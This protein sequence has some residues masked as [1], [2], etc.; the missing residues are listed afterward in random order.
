MDDKNFAVSYV[1]Q[2]TVIHQTGKSQPVPRNP[3][4][5][6]AG[7]LLVWCVAATLYALTL[8]GLPYLGAQFDR[9]PG[10]SGLVITQLDPDGP[11][12]K[13]GLKQDQRVLTL[14]NTAGGDAYSFTDIDRAKGRHHLPTY[15]LAAQS[16]QANKNIWALLSAEKVVFVDTDGR[17]F[18]LAPGRRATLPAQSYIGLAVS[19]AVFL[20][21]LGIFSFAPLN[22][23]NGLLVATGL[24]LTVVC[25]VNTAWPLHELA[26]PPVQKQ[27]W[28]S[29]ASTGLI[30]FCYGLLGLIWSVPKPIAGFPFVVASLLAGGIIAVSNSFELIEFPIHTYQFPLVITLPLAVII[31]VVQFFRTRGKPLERAAL[32]WFVLSIYS[33]IA[34]VIGLFSAPVLLGREPHLDVSYASYL[35]ALI[36]I[37]FA[38]GT[39]RVRLFDVNRLWLRALLWISGGVLVILL[40]ILLIS[41]FDLTQASSL[42][43]ALLIVGWIYFPIRQMIFSRFAAHREISLARVV[44]HLIEVFSKVENIEEID[45]RLVAFLK[46]VFDASELG[47]ARAEAL[48]GADVRQNGLVLQVPNLVNDRSFELLGK[49]RGR[50]LFSAGDAR[51]ANAILGLVRSIAATKAEQQQAM[52]LQKDA[53]VRDLHDEVGGRLLDIV[54]GTDEQSANQAREALSALKDVLLVIEDTETIE[55]SVALDAIISETE[56]RLK[57]MEFDLRIHRSSKLERILSTREYANLK[58]LFKE[59]V[60]NIIKF[61]DRAHPVEMTVDTD[62]SGALSI[63]QCNRFTPQERDAARHTE[64][65]GR[66]L[67]NMKNR[68][69]ELGGKL[70]INGNEEEDGRALFRLE[71]KIPT[72]G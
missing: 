55:L 48:E 18:E 49:K 23:T 26:L 61:A 2:S 66:G 7:G 37:G 20:I 71:F 46:E 35:L 31:S 59:L 65:T 54:Y 45:G 11:M 17:K 60:N 44:P 34:L 39:L 40:D 58:R 69:E 41:Q 56:Q 12:A 32:L 64:V 68:A 28:L 72:G 4:L 42:T 21:T 29:L 19:F 52:Q 51:T 6:V 3:K 47:L 8:L 15:D 13:A 1:A 30:F 9:E 43:L 10:Q 38:L 14:E 70:T 63:S 16:R 24:C 25:L 57:P 67:S 50:D 62:D 22:G 5:I 27:V 33:V 36:F 53:I